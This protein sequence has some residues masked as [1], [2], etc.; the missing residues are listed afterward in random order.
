ML[1]V[2]KQAGKNLLVASDN[3]NLILEEAKKDGTIPRSVTMSVTNDQS[4]KTRE[5]VSN[6]V[7]SILLGILLVVGVLL[8]FLGLRNALFVGVAIPLSMFMSFLILQC[9]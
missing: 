2:K 7:N 1:D 9:Q 5:M 3:I 6:L 8:F 4:N